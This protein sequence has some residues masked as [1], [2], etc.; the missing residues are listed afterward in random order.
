[1][2][3]PD[4]GKGYQV[5]SPLAIGVDYDESA[6]KI[7]S[8]IKGGY[9]YTAQRTPGQTAYYSGPIDTQTSFNVVMLAFESV[10]PQFGVAM[11]IPTGT[12]YLPNNQRFTRIDPDLAMVGSYGAGFNI[13]PTAG[14]VV[15]IDQNTAVSLSAGYA[16]QG[17]F[18]R[19]AINLNTPGVGA[20]DLK[21]YI[22]PGD[23]VTANF[24]LTTQV[25]NTVIYGSFAYMSESSV[26]INGIESGRAGAK[27][28]T[29]LTFNTQID[30]RWSV[31]TNLT[32]SY[33][34]KERHQRR[35]LARD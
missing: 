2:F 21:Q 17:K 27:Y 12:S 5:Y 8:R 18:V 19:E 31:T 6:F 34:G 4:R 23:V 14:F 32:W 35:G 29:N 20:F 13:N 30:D 24:N 9:V 28:N 11:N 25:A 22:N 26:T 15:G 3:Q 16:W 1:M 10:R 7:E 33:R